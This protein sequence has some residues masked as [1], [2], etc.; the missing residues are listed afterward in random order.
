MD[1]IVSKKTWIRNVSKKMTPDFVFYSRGH[2]SMY[3]LG[4]KLFY[5]FDTVKELRPNRFKDD[6]I[7]G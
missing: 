4:T 5:Q 7:R 1:N 2:I 3:D 6:P